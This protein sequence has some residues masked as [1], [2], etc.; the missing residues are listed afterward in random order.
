MG[1]ESG[2]IRRTAD[3]S[4]ELISLLTQLKETRR[5]FWIDSGVPKPGESISDHVYRVAMAA[6]VLSR[7][8]TSLDRTTLIEM[9]LIH[10]CDKV[11]DNDQTENGC[12][13]AELN[14]IRYCD[15][16]LEQSGAKPL[17]TDLWSC[18]YGDYTSAE[19]SAVR[20]LDKLEI[21]L[22]AAEYERRYW[23]TSK[24]VNLHDFFVHKRCVYP[25]CD[26]TMGR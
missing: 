24:E 26:Q 22:Q 19:A 15:S 17:F 21:I 14:A 11:M 10:D 18:F 9:A 1:K 23:G 7:I 3:G 13:E 20:Q 6:L 8:D 5:S 16:L 2:N 4:L 25:S 12:H